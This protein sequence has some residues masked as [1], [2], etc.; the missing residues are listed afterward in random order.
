VRS[1][2]WLEIGEISKKRSSKNF[3]S[4]FGVRPSGDPTPPPGIRTLNETLRGT[5]AGFSGCRSSVHPALP[6]GT[7]RPRPDVLILLL[8]RYKLGADLQSGASCCEAA[9]TT[10]RVE[11]KLVVVVGRVDAVDGTDIGH[12]HPQ[13]PPL[14]ISQPVP[15]YT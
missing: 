15:K 3:T 10:C 6:A 5:P 14:R 7:N 9:E 13:S 1:G 4:T 11:V 2:E 12:R 8:G